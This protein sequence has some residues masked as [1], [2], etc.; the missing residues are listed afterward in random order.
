[1]NAKDLGSDTFSVLSLPYVWDR[2]IEGEGMTV[3]MFCMFGKSKIGK[4][5]DPGTAQSVQTA[6]CLLTG[7][8]P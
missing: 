8:L 5:Q 3:L 2:I 1:M 7:A 4:P 6:H